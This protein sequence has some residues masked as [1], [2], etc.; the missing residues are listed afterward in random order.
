MTRKNNVTALDFTEHE[1]IAGL[2]YLIRLC[3]ADQISG[4]VFAVKLKHTR[5]RRHLYGTTGRLASNPD[6]ALSLAAIMLGHATRQAI[7][8]EQTG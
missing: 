4:I 1:S 8:N 7:E 3:E 2:R 6:E 5:K